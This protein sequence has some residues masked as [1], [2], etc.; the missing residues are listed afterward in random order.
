M[1]IQVIQQNK[2][3]KWL[4]IHQYLIFESGSIRV[5]R[6]INEK[7]QGKNI[8]GMTVTEQESDERDDRVGFI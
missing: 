4:D 2:Y 1:S 8:G 6:I 7:V 5:K 3:G